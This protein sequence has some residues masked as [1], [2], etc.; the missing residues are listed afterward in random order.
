ML[1]IVGEIVLLCYKKEALYQE[2]HA[3]FIP[4]LGICG[5]LIL[6]NFCL[7]IRVLDTACKASSIT[8]L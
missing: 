7:L 3:F 1:I 4:L 5:Q 2:L 6:R 8:S